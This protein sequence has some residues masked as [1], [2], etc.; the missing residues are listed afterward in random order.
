MPEGFGDITTRLKER[1]DALHSARE[2]ALADGRQIIQLSSK[3]IKHIH[4]QEFDTADKLLGELK[5]LVDTAIQH[6]A[7]SPTI[8]HAPY[9]QDAVKEYVEAVTL[10]AIVSEQPIPTPEALG[11]EPAAYLN[12]IC[13]SASECRRYALDELRRGNHAFARQ[14]V[15]EMEDIYDEL[16][17]FDY[18]DALT[19]NLR[20]NVDALR[21]VLER[22]QS[23]LAVT[24][25]QL[26][27]INELRKTRGDD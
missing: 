20:R 3:A 9:F 7:G 11:V 5:A 27:L 15:N 26:E 8:K 17:T 21:A 22:T 23:D 24:G 12:G 13:E 16:I 10:R 6:I 19:S 25:T 2:R 4:R 18:P 14:L 1:I